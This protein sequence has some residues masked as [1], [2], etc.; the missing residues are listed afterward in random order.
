MTTLRHRWNETRYAPRR[1][2][3]LARIY[4]RIRMA[5]IHAFRDWPEDGG[6]A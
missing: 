5:V 6:A 1:E 2:S 4:W 3:L